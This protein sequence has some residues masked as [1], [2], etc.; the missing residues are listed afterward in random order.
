MNKPLHNNK[1]ETIVEVL[2]S[3]V[4]LLIF[5]AVFAMG[6]SFSGRMARQATAIR[7]RT[8]ALCAALRPTDGST[9]PGAE[10]APKTYEFWRA[11]NNG[12][13]VLQV[14]T[15]KDVARETVAVTAATEEGEGVAHT[16]HRFT[17]PAA[18][19]DTP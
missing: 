12:D 3:F 1:G 2:V 14:F 8:Y 15:V 16:F 9:L 4:I 17:A 18:M 11:N 6:I 13:P 10:D 5:V 19:G 7:A